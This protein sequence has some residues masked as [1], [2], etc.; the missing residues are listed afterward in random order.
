MTKRAMC[1]TV[2]IYISCTAYGPRAAWWVAE[3]RTVTHPNC[4]R[5]PKNHD[6]RAHNW[7]ESRQKPLSCTEDSDSILS[8]SR[9]ISPDL[10][11]KWKFQTLY[12]DPPLNFWFACALCVWH[13]ENVVLSHRWSK[14]RWF[15]DSNPSRYA[16]STWQIHRTPLH[17][18]LAPLKRR[19]NGAVKKRCGINF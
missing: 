10:A 19:T 18:A 14:G 1:I 2:Y 11:E 8:F 5:K 4:T 12:F 13:G 15:A 6:V 3:V 16:T 9:G 7:K 17:C